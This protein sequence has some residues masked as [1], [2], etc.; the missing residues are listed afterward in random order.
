VLVS[1]G[2]ANGVG[3]RGGV[4]RSGSRV[5]GQNQPIDGA[6]NAGGAPS[7]HRVDV[8]GVTVNGDRVVQR[9]LGAGRRDVGGREHGRLTAVIDNDR[10]GETSCARRWARVS[11]RRGNGPLAANVGVGEASHTHQRGRVSRS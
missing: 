7:H 2:G 10:V 11:G 9:R 1:E 3:D 6:E 4:R 8:P 5:S